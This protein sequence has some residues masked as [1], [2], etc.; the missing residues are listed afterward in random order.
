M[1]IYINREP[2]KGPWGGGNKTVTML[3]NHLQAQGH[4]VVYTLDTPDLD[5]LFCF[6]P[7]P[8]NFGEWYQ[9]LLNYKAAS[10]QTRIIQRVGDLGTHGKPKLTS[11]VKQSVKL[12]DFLIFPSEWAKEQSE[13]LG[14]NGKVIH[15]APLSVFHKFKK[16]SD[17]KKDKVELITHHWSDN[18][19]KGFEIYKHLDENIIGDR[20]GLT[21]IGRL[22]SNFKFKNATY[23]SATGDNEFLAKRMSNSD[24]YFTAS[25]EEA[26][27]NHVLEGMA[28]GLPVVYH[29]NGGSINNYCSNY[30]IGYDSAEDVLE[31]LELAIDN[32]DELKSD[33]LKYDN[34]IE[35]VV[36][37]YADIIANCPAIK[38]G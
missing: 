30:G 26:G 4:D 35:N 32:F 13:F 19:K 27:A 20:F 25:E 12:S 21:Y 24:I 22:P 1:K 33:T 3:I 28:S 31:K 11:L 36:S 7:R 5:V 10:P 9:H 17:L 16:E 15:N 6:D 23:I 2:V 8:N 29:K 38:V 14:E 18:P 34:I 37:E